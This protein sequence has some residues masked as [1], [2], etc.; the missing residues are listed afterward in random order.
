MK[1]L[2]N[3]SSLMLYNLINLNIKCGLKTLS[4]HTSAIVIL[5]ALWLCD[6]FLGQRSLTVTALPQTSECYSARLPLLYQPCRASLLLVNHIVLC[7]FSEDIVTDVFKHHT[8]RLP[9][10][11]PWFFSFCFWHSFFISISYKT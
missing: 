8:D 2:I 9:V 7:I 5:E 1:L 11:V 10:P 6:V 4:L 3:K